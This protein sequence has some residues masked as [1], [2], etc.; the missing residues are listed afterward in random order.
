M[1]RSIEKELSIEDELYEERLY[2]WNYI[3]I[4]HLQKY[5]SLDKFKLNFKT[6]N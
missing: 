3:Q 2:I 6:K 5:I 4:L 1:F